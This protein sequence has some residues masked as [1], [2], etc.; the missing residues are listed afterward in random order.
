MTT[1]QW[2]GA[3]RPVPL[4]DQASPEFY[5]ELVNTGE[6]RLV[7]MTMAPGAADA[8]H[9]HPEEIVYFLSAGRLRI[10]LES[11]DVVERD[12][13]AGDVMHNEAWA[14]QVTN[15]GGTSVEAI[16]FER[17]DRDDLA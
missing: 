17:L 5:R 6:T 4:A 16:I 12:V 13:V 9:R 7:H 14:H 2:P 15:V 1:S 8:P 10:A 11:G 3:G